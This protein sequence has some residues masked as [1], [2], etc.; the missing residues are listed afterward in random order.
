MKPVVKQVSK[1]LIEFAGHKI[2]RLP[3]DAV[4]ECTRYATLGHYRCAVLQKNGNVAVYGMK[5]F[6]SNPHNPA[7]QHNAAFAL[8]RLGLVDREFWQDAQRR[9]ERSDRDGDINSLHSEAQRLGFKVI[10]KKRAG[11]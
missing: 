10:E 3:D 1:N 6:F 7:A 2:V 4:R 5:N 9:E 8:Y 11:K